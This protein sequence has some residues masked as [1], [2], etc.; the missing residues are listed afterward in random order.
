MVRISDGVALCIHNTMIQ[1]DSSCLETEEGMPAT[2][3]ETL[4]NIYD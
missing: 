3:N 4:Q 1:S 2:K